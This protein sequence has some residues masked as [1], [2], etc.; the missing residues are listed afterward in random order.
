MGLALNR[1]MRAA[2]NQSRKVSRDGTG[3]KNAGMMVSSNPS[4]DARRAVVVNFCMAIDY[5]TRELLLFQTAMR[6]TMMRM[7]NATDF[8]A[9]DAKNDGPNAKSEAADAIYA[10]FRRLFLSRGRWRRQG[11]PEHNKV[12]AGPGLGCLSPAPPFP[13]FPRVARLDIAFPDPR[14]LT[15][16]P[17]K[18]CA[19]G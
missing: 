7:R 8:L 5:Q 2:S 3:W 4:S 9:P 10:F 15:I 6:G 13:A 18:L 1:G 11:L 14:P 19:E 16:P 17:Q 12:W